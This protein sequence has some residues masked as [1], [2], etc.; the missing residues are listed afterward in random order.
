M[1]FGFAFRCLLVK[2]LGWLVDVVAK[3]LK[4]TQISVLQFTELDGPWE[5]T[6]ET[7]M[8]MA[9]MLASGSRHLRYIN[10]SHLFW[11][12]NR[13]LDGIVQLI[14]LGPR[15]QRGIELFDMMRSRRLYWD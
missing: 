2:T 9:K 4:L 13:D 8:L 3:L 11:E 7:L 5:L 15:W 6:D 14:K 10:V 1:V 12:V